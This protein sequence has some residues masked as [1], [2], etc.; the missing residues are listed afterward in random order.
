[1]T[2]R[3]LDRDCEAAAAL[4]IAIWGHNA[5]CPRPRS[6]H[7]RSRPRRPPPPDQARF[8]LERRVRPDPARLQPD[9]R[10]G[11]GL[12]ARRRPRRAGSASA[13]ATSSSPPAAPPRPCS[14]INAAHAA[15]GRTGGYFALSADAA[16]EPQLAAA[17]LGKTEWI[18]DVQGHFVNPTGAWLKN[19]PA[20]AKPLSGMRE[21]AM[22]ARRQAGRPRLSQLPR[23]VRVHQG[24]LPR[25]RHRPHGPLLRPLDPR[26]RAADHR[27]SR[28]DPR[29]RREDGGQQAADAPRPGQSQPA[30]RR[31][32]HGPARRLRG[33]RLQDLYPMGPERRRLLDDRR[34]RHRLRREGAQARHPQH[35]H[36]QGPARSARKATSIRPAATSA[37]SPGASRT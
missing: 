17:E 10:P 15:A 18:F 36:P 5:T 13:G 24:R 25:F 21:G 20:G 23:P 8:D 6:R 3:P 35:R 29:D 32:G 22:R 16:T 27:G 14:P 12:G 28:G 11:A 7:E 31:R 9:A 33:Q 26:G 34:R 19:V 1:M 2:S 4:A 30:R 37:R